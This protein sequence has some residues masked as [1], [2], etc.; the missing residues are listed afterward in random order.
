[1]ADSFDEVQPAAYRLHVSGSGMQAATFLRRER[2]STWGNVLAGEVIAERNSFCLNKLKYLEVRG[3]ARD[4]SRWL[5]RAIARGGLAAAFFVP[6]TLH[7]DPTK[8]PWAF[9][10]ALQTSLAALLT[11]RPARRADGGYLGLAGVQ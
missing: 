8:R 5:L 10:A 3:A 7:G 9:L 1:M 2:D 6:R 4:N 11:T